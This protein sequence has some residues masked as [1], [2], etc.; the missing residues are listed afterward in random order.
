VL[1]S[2]STQQHYG[3]SD[4]GSNTFNISIAISFTVCVC[5]TCNS[6]V[7]VFVLLGYGIS[8]VNLCQMFWDSVVDSSSVEVTI[9][10]KTTLS[11]MS[12]INHTVT[13]HKYQNGDLN[14]TA[15]EAYKLM[16]CCGTVFTNLMSQPLFL[17]LIIQ[18]TKW[19]YISKYY[20]FYISLQWGIQVLRDICCVAG[21]GF[22]AITHTT[23]MWEPQIPHYT[24]VLWHPVCTTVAPEYVLESVKRQTYNV[25]LPTILLLSEF[26][27]P[28]VLVV[29]IKYCLGLALGLIS[30]ASGAAESHT[31]YE[32][33]QCRH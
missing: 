15:V 22:G 30:P 13:R 11:G 16:F 28:V 25:K 9:K 29:L 2:T 5:L 19:T 23:L 3:S 32:S 1:F 33:C 4:G 26:N 14:C 8:S 17:T 21:W 31:V 10:G 18:W 7:E 20:C 27:I 12:G 6:A 24:E